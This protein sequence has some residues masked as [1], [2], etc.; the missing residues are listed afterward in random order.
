MK[1]SAV[2]KEELKELEEKRKRREIS[3]IEF[4]KGLMEILQKLAH[5]LEITAIKEEEARREIA[6]LLPFIKSQIKK[7]EMRGN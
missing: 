7:L 5:S 1:D 6:L 4:Y 2:F 3:A